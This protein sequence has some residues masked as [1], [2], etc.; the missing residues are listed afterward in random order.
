MRG[1]KVSQIKRVPVTAAI[2][3]VACNPR[4]HKVSPRKSSATLSPERSAKIVH[5]IAK[6]D[7]GAGPLTGSG[8]EGRS[9]G[10]QAASA[11]TDCGLR[12]DTTQCEKVWAKAATSVVDGA[13]LFGWWHGYR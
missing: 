1:A 3:P 9:A 2:G 7:T 13:D 6:S 8:R 10:S 11:A 12:G 5:A 4:P